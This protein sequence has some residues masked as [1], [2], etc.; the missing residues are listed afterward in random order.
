MPKRSKTPLEERDYGPVYL[1]LSGLL[2]LTTF[3]AI[4]DMIDLRAPWQDYQQELN[5]LEYKNVTAELETTEE[6]LQQKSGDRLKALREQL[7]QAKAD[8]ESQ[9]YIDLQ[10]DLQKVEVEIEKSMQNYRFAK[11]EFDALWYKYKHAQH[12]GEEEKAEAIF[13]KATSLNEEVTELKSKWDTAEAK[14]EEIEARIAGYRSRIDSLQNEI[15]V[16]LAPVNELKKRKELIGDRKIEIKQFI[17]SDFVKGNFGNFIDRVDRCTSCHVNADKSSYDDYPK[18]FKTHP[19][20]DIYL[21][22]HPVNQFGCT[23]CHEGQGPALQSADFAHGFV[24]FW[25]HPLLTDGFEEA[26]CNKCH[27]KEMRVDHAPALSKAKRMVYDLACYACHEIAGYEDAPKIGPPLNDVTAK[28]TSDFIYRWVRDTKSL[29]QHTRM[30]NP[31]FSHEEAL[32]VTA[33]LTNISKDSDYSPPPAPSSGSV[34]RGKELVESLGCKGCHVVTERDREIRETDVPYDI[35]PE[36]TKIGSK[37]N[38]DW[39]YAWIK[40]PKQYNPD[41]PMPRLRLTNSEARDI[42]AYLMTRTE[43]G[44]LV[45]SLDGVDLDAEELVSEGKAIIRNFGCHGCHE[46]KGMEGEG[47]V[48]VS[49]NEFGAKTPEELFFGDALARGEVPEETWEAWTI[50]KLKNSRA[51]ATEQV[52]QRMPNFAFSEEDA[53]TLAALLKSWDGRTIGANYVHDRGRIGHALEKGRRLARHYNCIG[54][55]I[56]EGRGGFIRPTVA[57][58]LNVSVDEAASFAPPDLVGEG[59]KVQPK[60]LFEFL[61]DPTTQIRPWLSVRMPTFDFSDDEANDLIEYFQ[62]LE[63]VSEP[64]ME[65]EVELTKAEKEAAEKLYSDDYLSCFSCHQVG[66]KKPEGGPEGWAPDFLL[67]PDRLNPDWV[68]DWIEN[69]Q[70]L[71]PG[72]KMPSFYPDIAQALPDILHGDPDKQIEALRDYLMNIRKYV[73]N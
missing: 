57:E 28:T 41:T 25:E 44:K 46:I 59:R 20:H 5:Q 3:W 24:K 10:S 42:T 47:K 31:Q 13:P 61:K 29:R 14:K 65:V 8:L 21:D 23:P 7:E 37:V 43:N 22:I 50:G 18:P 40:N 12:H 55:H 56:I 9:A 39:L 1:I 35:A 6:Q 45:S 64:F 68:F 71:Q 32:A 48:S 4:V 36:L 60:W 16:M 17:L 58:H 66:D 62:A 51:Y 15:E 69:P 11:S 54:C 73:R 72:T 34:E 26:G 30:P 49:L 19:K 27:S 63:G 38:R 67:A 33:Y 52:I 2:A 70:A 53:R